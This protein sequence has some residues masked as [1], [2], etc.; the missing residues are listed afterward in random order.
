MGSVV[1]ASKFSLVAETHILPA[2]DR[3]GLKAIDCAMEK[4]RASSC[5]TVWYL[6]TF[7]KEVK[8]IWSYLGLTGL[9]GMLQRERAF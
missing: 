7:P 9:R 5:I 2:G 1:E 6:S 8:W 3:G 4:E